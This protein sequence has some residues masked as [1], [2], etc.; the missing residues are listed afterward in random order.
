MIWVNQMDISI[1]NVLRKSAL[2]TSYQV[3]H[4][5]AYSATET[6]QNLKNLG[7]AS[8][9]SFSSFEAVYNYVRICVDRSEFFSSQSCYIFS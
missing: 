6:S 7:V 8:L 1:N 5:P 9:C 3:R 2:E 4:K